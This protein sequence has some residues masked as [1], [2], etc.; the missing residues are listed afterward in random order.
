[1]SP[2]DPSPS[3]SRYAGQHPFLNIGETR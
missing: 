2:R 1:V 3:F